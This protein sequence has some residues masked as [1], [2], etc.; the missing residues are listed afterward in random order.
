MIIAE[1]PFYGTWKGRVLEAI[2]VENIRDWNGIWEYTQLQSDNLNKALSELYNLDIITRQEDNHL[3]WI[4]DIVLLHQ[5][6]EYFD[7]INDD[8]KAPLIQ[9]EEPKEITL[10]RALPK[11]ENLANFV[12]E[13]RAF[14]NLSFSLDAR[15]F[16]LEGTYLDDLSKDLIRRAKKEVLLVNPFVVECNLSNTLIDAVKNKAKVTV[17]TRSPSGFGFDNRFDRPEVIEEKQKYHETLIKEGI[18]INYEPRI[19]AKLIVV[20]N[21]I[22]IISSMNFVTSSSGGSSWEAGMISIDDSIVNSVHKT[23]LDLLKKF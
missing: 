13:W 22:A 4:K 1:P 2:A 3:Y 12:V 11:D 9:H 10:K 7:H 21:Q 8:Y 20:D 16:F 23:I 5:Y 6:R 15:H 18:K 14:K 19:H 17:I